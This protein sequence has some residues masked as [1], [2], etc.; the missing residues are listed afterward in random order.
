LA[1]LVADVIHENAAWNAIDFPTM[2]LLFGLMVVSAQFTMSG[3]YTAVTA[4]L[5]TVRAS[6]VVLLA[7]IVFAVGALSALLTNNVVAVAMAPLLVSA[8]AARKLNPVPFLLA[9][10]FA[11]NAGSVATII[12]SPQNMIVA[13][14]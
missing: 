11:A 4:R 10:G 6:P 1:L 13:T 12:G 8:C 3:F 5:A 14:R 9:L 2:A 7:V